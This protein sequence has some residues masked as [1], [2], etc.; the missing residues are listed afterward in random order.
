MVGRKREDRKVHKQAGPFVLTVLGIVDLLCLVTQRWMDMENLL[1]IF[2]T[3]HAIIA[4]TEILAIW[5]YMP[6]FAI[7][8]TR[9]DKH[10]YRTQDSSVKHL[11]VGAPS[12]NLLPISPSSRACSMRLLIK[13]LS[14]HLHKAFHQ[15]PILHLGKVD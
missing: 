5:P 3:L 2:L 11:T 7:W 8:I 14:L 4:S 12:L 9:A 1:D 15:H 13:Q 10:A 6:A